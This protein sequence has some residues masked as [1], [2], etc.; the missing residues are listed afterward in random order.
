M[1]RYAFMSLV[2]FT[3][4]MFPLKSL[5]VADCPEFRELLLSV[6]GDITATEIPHR[7]KLRELVIQGWRDYFQELRSDLAVCLLYLLQ[8]IYQVFVSRL[9]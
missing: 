4:L 5:N 8:Y 9:L 2:G 3:T 1:I 6:G 7:S